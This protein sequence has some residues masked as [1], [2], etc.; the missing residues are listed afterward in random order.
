MNQQEKDRR[1]FPRYCTKAGTMALNQTIF[2]PIINISMK[3]ML[4]EYYGG[5]ITDDEIMNVG[6][7]YLDADFLLKDMKAKTVRDRPIFHTEGI[8]PNIRKQRA[9]EFIELTAFQRELLK[10]FIATHTSEIVTSS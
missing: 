5:D 3:G 2:G 4:F 7:Y 1:S 8:L 6:L 10:E 9:V